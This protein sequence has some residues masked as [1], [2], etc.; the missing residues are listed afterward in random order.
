VKL[1]SG[2]YLLLAYIGSMELFALPSPEPVSPT[3]KHA[4]DDQC[5]RIW[6]HHDK[7]DGFRDP[8]IFS[9]ANVN[10][11]TVDS[12]FVLWS[13]ERVHE[14][15][16]SLSDVTDVQ[17]RIISRTI[18]TDMRKPRIGPWSMG[19]GTENVVFPQRG[20]GL[21]MFA[22]AARTSCNRG[23]TRLDR[24]ISLAMM[25]TSLGLTLSP[26]SHEIAGVSMDEESGIIFLYLR[27]KDLPHTGRQYMQIVRMI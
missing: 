1:L 15:T 4:A 13:H 12:P 6:F 23:L 22:P 3:I 25:G 5:L 2:R 9:S 10:D 11:P 20:G 26:E 17:V 21:Y 27:D 18:D 8:V 14:V 7:S 19:I 24:K 16:I